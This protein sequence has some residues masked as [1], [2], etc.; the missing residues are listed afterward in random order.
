MLKSYGRNRYGRGVS[1]GRGVQG[2]TGGDSLDPSSYGGSISLDPNGMGEGDRDYLG[3]NPSD[4]AVGGGING[5][6]SSWGTNYQNNPIGVRRSGDP[7]KDS[8]ESRARDA[9]WEDVFNSDY[10]NKESQQYDDWAKDNGDLSGWIGDQYNNPGYG[11]DIENGILQ[12]GGLDKGYTSDDEYGDNQLSEGEQGD[13]KGNVGSRGAWFNPGKLEGADRQAA[14]WS[15]GALD[16]Y[17]NNVRGALDK[18]DAQVGDELNT[19]S[20][21]VHGSLDSSEAATRGQIAGLG[22]GLRDNAS[23]YQSNAIGAIDPNKLTLSDDEVNQVGEEAGR[24]VGAQYGSTRDRLIANAKA[25][26]QGNPLAIAAAEGR[27]NHDSAVSGADATADARIQALQAQKEGNKGVA[28]M[29]LATYGKA[30][31]LGETAAALPGQLGTN[32]E[33]SMGGRRVDAEAGLGNTRA[34]YANQRSNARTGAE[35]D[36]GQAGIGVESANGN[37]SY[38]TEANNQ[39]FGTDVARDADTTASTRAATIAGNRQQTN[40]ANQANRWSQA[41][42]GTNAA[43]NRYNTI[44]QA[45]Q[46]GKQFATSGKA[47]Q[48]QGAQ[49]AATKWA[50]IRNQGVLGAGSNS[51]QAMATGA[52]YKTNNPSFWSK[53]LNGASQ[54]AMLGL[55]G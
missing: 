1:Q 55:G 53:A 16:S 13:I 52:A 27:L 48:T 5:G 32:A 10:G 34:G 44:G 46:Q 7:Y 3:G 37:R 39:Q 40:Q 42:A 43:S 2:D 21:N 29:R 50:T 11:Q 8:E 47:T 33:L 18:G 14:D 31:D 12:N 49:D 24:Q 20:N 4:G 30:A 9:G 22:K 15:R 45:R 51:N 28:N 26:G 25:A 41:L 19:L 35:G 36:I 17:G 6:G 23:S 38:Q 54:A